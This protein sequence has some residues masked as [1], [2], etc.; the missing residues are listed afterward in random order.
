MQNQPRMAARNMR[1][2]D[3]DLRSTTS[4]LVGQIRGHRL[5]TMMGVN[6]AQARAVVVCLV[7]MVAAVSASDSATTDDVHRTVGHHD[8]VVIGG[9]PAAVQLLH[10]LHDSRR[11]AVLFAPEDSPA[12]WYSRC[13]K[14]GHDCQL[15]LPTQVLQLCSR[16]RSAPHTVRFAC[17][18]ARH[19][20]TLPKWRLV[21]T[22]ARA[23]LTC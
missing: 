15:H 4:R 11:N 3:R 10:L 5:L 18:W 17:S 2:S 22:V 14:R 8:I 16:R 6:E 7:M 19:Q 12:G 23:S 1:D 9:G 21:R 13:Q 20:S